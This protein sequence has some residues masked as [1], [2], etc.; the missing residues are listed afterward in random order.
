MVSPITR[1]SDLG[2]S[3]SLDNNMARTSK[4][5][6]QATL[7][8][9]SG[10][11]LQSFADAGEL[12]TRIIN[13]E[14]TLAGYNKFEQ[15][16]RTLQ[17]RMGKMEI[18]TNQIND[19]AIEFRARANKAISF[20]VP[21]SAFQDYCKKQ[22]NEIE[23]LL[24]SQ[25]HEGRYLFGGDA[26]STPPVDMSLLTAPAIGGA[27]NYDYYQGSENLSVGLMGDNQKISYGVL[28]KDD[29]I[30]NLVNA[31]KIGTLNFPSNTPTSPGYQRL[32]TDI[33][34]LAEKAAIEIPDILQNIGATT[35][36]IEQSVERQDTIKSYT[37]ELLANL[38][39]TNP[40]EVMKELTMSQISL[41][42]SM[43]AYQKMIQ[44]SED[45]LSAMRT[46]R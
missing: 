41:E 22:L 2:V 20:G 6:E 46:M 3:L 12:T 25:D 13:L 38:I 40:V 8:Q 18:I 1:T 30:A 24:N 35:K 5:I 45:L 11:K 39:E 27:I 17:I 14:N 26:T 42:F 7:Q 16:E 44:G 29:G 34:P 9:T 31:L 43:L 21:D 4:R 28:A 33:I 37:Q 32:K 36:I 23:R 15:G 10:L 19:I